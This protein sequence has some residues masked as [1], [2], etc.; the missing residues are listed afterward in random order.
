MNSSETDGQATD[1]GYNAR[2]TKSSLKVSEARLV[3]QALL[4]SDSPVDALHLVV[5]SNLL[6]K[7]S[8]STTSTL[9]SILVR[10]LAS[11]H[12]G[13]WS[14]VA[15]GGPSEATIAVM[16]ATVKSERLL[17]DYMDSVMREALRTYV[18]VLQAR[19]WAPFLEGCAEL[20]P[21]VTRWT[22]I[23]RAKLRENINRILAESRY[24]ADTRT[25]MLQRVHV[26]RSLSSLLEA[27]GEERV[28]RI[29][30]VAE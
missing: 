9:A 28:L 11:L 8:P 30:Q 25:L 15:E 17:A 22:P 6:Q 13:V 12:R 19:D 10:R 29:L 27:A 26:P 21:V 4:D 14:L 16:A 7:R 3:A 1:A 18:P 5:R 23:V 24:V 20:D 2:L